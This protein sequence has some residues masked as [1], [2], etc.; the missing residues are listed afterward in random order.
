MISKLYLLEPL[1]LVGDL[2]K[3]FVLPFTQ[4]NGTDWSVVTLAYNRRQQESYNAR[5]T[6]DLISGT[7]GVTDFVDT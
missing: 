2:R 5:N 6:V 3:K 1:C 4:K 7:V